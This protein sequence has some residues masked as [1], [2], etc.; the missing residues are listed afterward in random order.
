MNYCQHC[1][2]PLPENAT[3]C[4]VC[5]AP[6][7]PANSPQQGYSSP[8]PR[9][10]QQKYS[11]SG[12]SVGQS[13][14]PSQ[15]QAYSQAQYQQPQQVGSIPA[16]SSLP[17]S[18]GNTSQLKRAATGSAAAASAQSVSG[19]TAP[20]SVKDY[21]IMFLLL[22]IPFA[23]LILLIVWATSSTTNVNK[24]N[25]ARAVCIMILIGFLLS[26]IFGSAIMAMM[27]SFMQSSSY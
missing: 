14:Y 26:L 16:S 6:V 27:T 18:S 13:S 23:N 24:R 3:V 20:M 5:G 9:Y 21:V 7:Q 17:L 11:G 15:G 22:A 25:Y 12:M 8:D 2:Y 19:P 10:A 1:R 4:G